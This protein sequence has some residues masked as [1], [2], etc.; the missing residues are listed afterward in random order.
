MAPRL[1]PSDE[2][3]PGSLNVPHFNT[4]LGITTT[5]QRNEPL[6]SV[7]IARHFGM[8]ESL[9]DLIIA[10]RLMW[11]GHVARMNERFPKTLLF[12][13]LPQCRPAHGVKMRWRDRARKDLK[14]FGVAETSWYQMAQERCVWRGK[15]REGLEAAM[16]K[17]VEADKL[18][19]ET[20]RA[21]VQATATTLKCTTNQ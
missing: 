4:I 2:M 16:E 6:S 3:L 18:R 19:K 10:R 11:L 17:Q 15:Y 9:E 5:Q 1:G 14:R 12:G 20:L 7:Q 13:W 21:G 8:E